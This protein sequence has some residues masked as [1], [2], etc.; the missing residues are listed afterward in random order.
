[1]T[2]DECSK[3]TDKHTQTVTDI[4]LPNCTILP[5]V[6]RRVNFGHTSITLLPPNPIS[7]CLPLGVSHSCYHSCKHVYPQ[8]S[9]HHGSIDTDLPIH[10]DCM[11]HFSPHFPSLCTLSLWTFHLTSSRRLYKIYLTF[12]L[13]HS[14]CQEPLYLQAPF[15][16]TVSVALNTTS[17]LSTAKFRYHWVVS[18]WKFKVQEQSLIHPR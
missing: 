18:C 7:C 6:K 8:S 9:C 16:Y 10:L 11:T 5:L 15:V 12:L 1:M 2:Y 3:V 17:L 4:C 14:L 13:L